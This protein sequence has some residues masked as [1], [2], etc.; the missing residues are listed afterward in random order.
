MPTVSDGIAVDWS[1][2]PVSRSLIA[3]AVQSNQQ[4]IRR[5]KGKLP[6]VKADEASLLDAMARLG[7]TGILAFVEDVTV[8]KTGRMAV[9]VSLSPITTT[10]YTDKSVQNHAAIIFRAKRWS[11]ISS[12]SGY[13]TFASPTGIPLLV[14]MPEPSKQF[15]KL[16]KIKHA[17]NQFS[18]ARYLLGAYERR[19]YGNALRNGDLNVPKTTSPTHIID[20][21]LEFSEPKQ[22]AKTEK[23]DAEALKSYLKNG[24]Q[25]FVDG[26]GR[27]GRTTAE[28]GDLIAEREKVMSQFVNRLVAETESAKFSVRN[29]LSTTRLVGMEVLDT[30]GDFFR[31]AKDGFGIAMEGTLR[32]FEANMMQAIK[33]FETTLQN[34]GI[35]NPKTSRGRGR[36][37]RERIWNDRL[38]RGVPK[39]AEAAKEATV[40][41]EKAILAK[42]AN[43]NEYAKR[44]G[45]LST[46][47]TIGEFFE[48]ENWEERVK[49]VFSEILETAGS[50]I[51]SIVGRY[52]GAVAGG[53]IGALGG[54]AGVLVGIAAGYFAGAFLGGFLGSILGREIADRLS[55]L[56][57]ENMSKAMEEIENAVEAWAEQYDDL[58]AYFTQRNIEFEADGSVKND[59][60]LTD[61]ERD[62]KYSSGAGPSGGK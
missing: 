46:A 18:A 15:E 44:L 53:A 2:A 31:V 56:L 54:P 43:F 49:I 16:F 11:R 6:L 22:Q 38:A 37:K 33:D 21:L 58:G 60:I 32:R 27:V 8:I 51:F 62:L 40:K 25:S 12:S 55:P 34:E 7:Q 1:D 59:S 61:L 35:Q 3:R 14:G 13:H 19:V 57:I 5:L 23:P 39:I 41:H 50:I 9:E 24:L 20:R 30:R 26:L 42:L 47:I 48:A 36:R 28:V 45:R 29:M 4:E 52:V 10:G 17:D